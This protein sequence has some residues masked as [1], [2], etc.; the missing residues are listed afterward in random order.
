MRAYL[1]FETVVADI[2]A[3]IDE[4]ARRRGEGRF[5]GAREELTR[6]EARAAKTLPISTPL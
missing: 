6:L 3:R 4:I 5:A 1:S 2:D